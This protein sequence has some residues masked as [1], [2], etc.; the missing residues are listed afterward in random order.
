MVKKYKVSV[1]L[2]TYNGKKY[3]KRQLESIINQTYSVDEIVVCD[4]Y[5]VDD[6]V[7]IIAEYEKKANCDFKFIKNKQNLGY[8][9]NF[10][11]AIN[12]CTGEIIFLSDQDDIWNEKKVETY[13]QTFN[14]DKNIGLVFSNANLINEKENFLN[15]TLSNIYINETYLKKID[16][17]TVFE[18]LIKTNFITGATVAFKKSLFEQISN[19]PDEWVHDHF[20]A[21]MFSDFTNLYY[22]KCCLTN[23]RLHQEQ[24]I[25][26]TNKAIKLKSY[27]ARLKKGTAISV[28]LKKLE[29]L[30]KYIDILSDKNKNILMAYISFLKLRL[31]IRKSLFFKRVYKIIKNKKLYVY[32]NKKSLISDLFKL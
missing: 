10:N 1:A 2:C 8:V 23:Y 9:K 24:Q 17:G 18:V 19:I 4:D 20:I 16:N 26:I 29:S 32:Y 15:K 27:L 28:E 6:T 7:K 14:N 11:K 31:E 5:S 30:D 22:E 25:G 13:L 3:L 12:I 21:L